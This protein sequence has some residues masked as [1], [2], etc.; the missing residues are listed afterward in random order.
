M[1]DIL[2]TIAVQWSP[3]PSP[4]SMTHWNDSENSTQLQN[5]QLQF[6]MP[7]DYR[8][9]STMSRGMFNGKR[10]FPVVLSQWKWDSACLSHDMCQTHIEYC[11][12]GK[13]NHDLVSR[14]SL[15]HTR[16]HSWLPTC[17]TFIS[18]GGH[19]D[20]LNLGSHHQSHG[21]MH[22]LCSSRSQGK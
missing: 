10:Q 11:W 19:T 5:S 3:R 14:V 7:K 18:G 16:R 22:F 15:G 13:S 6:I 1:E 4:G 8:L 9:K 12:E 21:S 2:Y 17:L 20:S